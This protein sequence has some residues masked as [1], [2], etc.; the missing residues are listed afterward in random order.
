M[1]PPLHLRLLT[2]ADIS[3]AD[4]LRA[5]AGWNQTTAD[6]ERLLALAPEGCF[7]A[8]WARTPAGVITTTAH[9]GNLAWIGMALV[10]P[11][12]RRKGVG[13]ALLQ[14]AIDHLRDQG[15]RC[16]KLDATP[17]GQPLY[18]SLGFVPEWTLTRWE[19]GA[20]PA[21]NTTPESRF[22]VRPCSADELAAAVATLDQ[23]A[24]G[25]PRPSLLHS[26]AEGSIS[27]YRAFDPP[28]DEQAFALLR[29]GSRALYLGPVVATTAELA[30][31][32]A[33]TALRPYPAKS[34]FWDI[35]DEN[36]VAA[37]FAKT[38]HFQ[39]QRSLTRMYHGQNSSPGQPSY[40]FGI[41]GP[42][43]G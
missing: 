4:S 5:L 1:K 39:P 27:I 12:H 23:F 6:W 13:R 21:Q 41:A 28:R 18:H 33:A 37:E 15:I 8:E 16:I 38:L 40:I 36:T 19:R 9:G 43:L 2:P 3:F 25:A 10:H 29:P 20:I 30:L 14:R 34:I 7:L 32:A 31:A 35:P 26:L 22:E 17:Q 42:E 11:E 24:F